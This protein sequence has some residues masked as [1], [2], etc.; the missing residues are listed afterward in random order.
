M[1]KYPSF[2]LQLEQLHC[3]IKSVHAFWQKCGLES[4]D[5]D[6]LDSSH[7][8]NDFRLNLMKSQKVPPPPAGESFGFLQHCA[9]KLLT[10]TT[11]SIS[12]GENTSLV[13]TLFI[14][15]G[16]EYDEKALMCAPVKRQRCGVSWHS[17]ENV[18]THEDVSKERSASNL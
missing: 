15:V 3:Y 17:D 12:C 8:T 16:S 4:H 1:N 6:P 18:T 10:H 2:M 13:S 5:V 9:L 7:S 11:T 14:S